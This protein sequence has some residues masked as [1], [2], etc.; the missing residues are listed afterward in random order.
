MYSPVGLYTFCYT[1]V[2]PYTFSILCITSPNRHKRVT[3]NKKNRCG[4]LFKPLQTLLD[5]FWTFTRLSCSAIFDP[6]WAN[7]WLT[8]PPNV[9]SKLIRKA[10]LCVTHEKN[11]K[12]EA[13]VSKLF[14]T[15]WK[16]VPFG[17]KTLIFVLIKRVQIGPK[18][19]Y[20]VKNSCGDRFRP[21]RPIWTTIKHW[22]DR[23][24]SHL[25]N[26]YHTYNTKGVEKIKME[27]K[28]K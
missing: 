13:P 17:P 7:F 4:A 11:P 24:E 27:F 20:M 15:N 3:Y 6:K 18:G 22:Q 10:H 23:R 9:S 25:L 21:L 16:W 28:S 14:L 1:C 12:P 2:E 19:S 26:Q 5:R 8:Q